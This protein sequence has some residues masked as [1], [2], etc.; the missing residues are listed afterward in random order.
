MPKPQAKRGK[1]DAADVARDFLQRGW[2]PVPVPINQ[3]APRNNAWQTL[4]ITEANVEHNFDL[5]DNVGLQLGSCSNG[6][7]DV[8]IDCPEALALADLILPATGAIFGRQ[9]K[10]GAHRLYVTDLCT[11]EKKAAIQF[12]E[13]PGL[14]ANGRPVMLV[15]LRIGAGEKGAQTIAPG[16]VHPSGEEVRWDNEGDPTS[17]SGSHLKTA[18]TELAVAAFLVRHYPS[19]G[20][21]HEG[22]LVLGGV[23]ARRLDVS[24]EGIRKFVVAIAR[25]AG[26]DEAEERGGAAAGAVELLKREQPTPGLPRM[27]EVWGVEVADTVARWLGLAGEDSVDEIAR[28]ARLD[29]LSYERE[30]EDAAARLGIRVSALDRLVDA[31]RQGLQQDG[32]SE[33]L[34]P[35]E[36]WPEPVDGTELF[37]DLCDVFD[38]HVVL[39]ESAILACAL[40]T[41]HAHTQDA[42]THSPILDISSPTPRCGKT[43]LLATV[44]MLVPKPLPAANV[45]A[46][47]VFRAIERWHPTLL[48]DEADTF[49]ADKSD[50]RGV[51]D[52]GHRKSSA[53]I[54]RC[55]GDDFEPKQFSTWCPKVF[56]HIGR[57]HPTLEDRAVR[58]T[59][60][61]RLKDEKIERIP[62]GDAYVELRRKCAR[63]GI[64]TFRQLEEAQPKIPDVLNDRAADNWW[65][66]L[67]IADACRFGK[68]ARDAAL[69]LS[70]CDD[71]ETDAIVLL[72]DLAELFDRK[73]RESPS[74][75]AMSS[76][77]IVEMLATLEDRK[78]PEFRGGRP[79]TPTQLATLLKPFEIRPRKVQGYDRGKQVQGYRFDQFDATFRRY[80]AG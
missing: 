39:S 7:T 43:Q 16:S 47:T 38:R 80:L 78:W 20:S 30:R 40:W 49:M 41:L 6:L 58:I 3:K 51:L 35:A 5:D 18:A 33:F 1:F 29:L 26:D 48:I 64:D 9:S 46:A 57:V 55:V 75:V 36:P 42:A 73:K 65:P 4:P 28:L 69:K 25:A 13:P 74:A 72:G 67:A 44:S 76:V 27:R 79:I 77:E 12:R 52:S 66:L 19:V 71:D 53:F 59:L 60:R 23:L 15:E 34:A 68:E 63:W 17:V 10:P 14:S 22:A 37:N 2:K 56:A 70:G 8:D 21:R 24:T 61:R 32:G 11:T 62:K 50:L 45:T 54:L 31:R